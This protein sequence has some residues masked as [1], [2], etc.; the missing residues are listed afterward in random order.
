MRPI[1]V[2]PMLDWLPAHE[3]CSPSP[4]LEFRTRELVVLERTGIGLGKRSV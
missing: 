1:A 4:K 2:Q 3:T